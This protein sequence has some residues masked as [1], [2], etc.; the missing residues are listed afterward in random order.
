MNQPINMGQKTLNDILLWAA[1]RGDNIQGTPDQVQEIQEQT[2]TYYRRISG[3]EL[4]A[5]LSAGVEGII[6]MSEKNAF[7]YLP[8]VE[9]GNCIVPI[10]CVDYDYAT[11][12]PEVT[13]RI[14]LF[15]IDNG[16]NQKAIG[17][18]FETG[19]GERRHRYHHIQHIDQLGKQKLQGSEW[20]PT[21][22]PAIPIDAQDP[23]DLVV[24]MLVCLYD[25]EILKQ[26]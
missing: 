17:Y 25:L 22:Y 26:S 21:E 6:S 1:Q 24:C 2:A 10:L 11:N 13:L 3:R 9:K 14:A 7:I 20:I 4:E 16:G 18:R 8:P 12:T 23:I 5:L 15:L 19:H